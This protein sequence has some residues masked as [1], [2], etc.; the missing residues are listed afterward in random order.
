MALRGLFSCPN[1]DQ[2]GLGG[3]GRE[4][5]TNR[6]MEVEKERVFRERGSTFSLEFPTIGPA[7]SDEARSKVAPHDKDYTWVPVLGSFDKLR[8]GRGF[9]PTCFTFC[10]RAM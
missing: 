4:R 9:S 1:L 7:S 8:K 2:S 5:E 6:E 3:K 10:L